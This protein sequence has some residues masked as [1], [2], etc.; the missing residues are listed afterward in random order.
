MTTDEA[1][2]TPYLLIGTPEQMAEQL[3]A[4]R[5]RSARR[6]NRLSS[7]SVRDPA[8]NSA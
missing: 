7:T 5:D 8:I 6:S 1:L 4:S 3:L 2:E